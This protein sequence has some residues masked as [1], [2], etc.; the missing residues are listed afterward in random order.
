MKDMESKKIKKGDG[1]WYLPG[2][3]YEY[4]M[5]IKLLKKINNIKLTLN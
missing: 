1:N 2:T 3:P 5:E 4:N